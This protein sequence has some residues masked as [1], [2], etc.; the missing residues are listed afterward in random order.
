MTKIE[1]LKNNA[2]FKGLSDADLKEILPF[3]NDKTFDASVNIFERGER[4]KEFFLLL[5]GDVKLQIPTDK[6]YGLAVVFIEEGNAF[7]ISGLLEPHTYSSTARC[8]KK[9]KVVAIEID[10]FLD[11]ISNKNIKSGF[12]IMKNLARILMNRLDITRQNLKDLVSQVNI[13]IP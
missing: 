7:G 13:S 12:L 4:G 8:V 1:E 2:L 6:E 11:F 5:D 3:C 9:S 10:P